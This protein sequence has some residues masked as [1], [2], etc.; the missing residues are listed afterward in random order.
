MFE[1]SDLA[2]GMTKLS[3]KTDTRGKQEAQHWTVKTPATVVEWGRH[4]RGECIIGISPINSKNECKW[5][6]ID[7]DNYK[8]PELHASLALRVADT[9]IKAVVSYSKSGG[10]HIFVLLDSFLPAEAVV[11]RMQELAAYLGHASAE[12]FPKQTQV[13]PAGAD[14]KTQDYGNWIS[15]PFWGGRQ[16]LVLRAH[17]GA[18]EALGFK[19]FLEKHEEFINEAGTFLSTELPTKDTLFP[20]GPPCLNQLFSTPSQE[21]YRNV[22]LSNTAVYAKQAFPDSWQGQIQKYNALF[23]NPLPLKEVEAI[24][25]SYSRKDYKYQCRVEP[26]KGNC[27]ARKCRC[28]KFG[29]GHQA[30]LPGNQ[31]LSMI[32]TEP[33]IWYLD[34]VLKDGREKRISL[35]TE[36]LQNPIGFQKRCMEVLQEMPPTPDRKEWQ[37]NVQEMMASVKIIDVPEEMTREGQFTEMI[38]DFF[39]MGALNG[40]EDDLMRGLPYAEDGHCYFRLRDLNTYMI[41]QRFTQ[42]APNEVISS[43]KRTLRGERIARIVQGRSMNLWKVPTVQTSEP[44]KTSNDPY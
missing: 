2:H 19:E 6:A 28:V 37:V 11:A 4:L 44:A 7:I 34:I 14:G 18:V 30:V 3:H 16:P 26:L 24:L 5:G 33:P 25:R 40:S 21:G 29:I 41:N 8:S 36:Q 43:I 17:D 32:A 39:S 23:D 38:V 20:E 22:L 35:S 13:Q 12:I 1:G 9:G 27:N 10:A 42:L 31:S 15:M